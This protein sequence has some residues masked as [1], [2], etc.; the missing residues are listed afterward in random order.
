MTRARIS[1]A[2]AALA[3]VSIAGV[4]HACPVCFDPNE[5]NRTAFYLTTILLSALPLAMGGGIFLWVRKNLE[6][7]DD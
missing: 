3:I 5:S 7:R 6:N 1:A 2:L 4:A